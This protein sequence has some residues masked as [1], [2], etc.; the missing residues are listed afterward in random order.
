MGAKED[1]LVDGE[2]DKSLGSLLV[3]LCTDGGGESVRLSG[4]RDEEDGLC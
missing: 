3:V 1:D 4:R 2:D